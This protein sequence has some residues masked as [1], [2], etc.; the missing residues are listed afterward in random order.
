MALIVLAALIV[1]TVV[2]ITWGTATA[3]VPAGTGGDGK[4]RP[5]SRLVDHACSP[6]Y[7]GIGGAALIGIENPAAG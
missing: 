5:G 6:P 2:A 7:V 4:G 3:V 1:T